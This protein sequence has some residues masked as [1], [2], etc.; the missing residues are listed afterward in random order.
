MIAQQEQHQLNNKN[1]TK[2]PCL[3]TMIFYSGIHLNEGQIRIHEANQTIELKRTK[4]K[5]K[6]I[7]YWTLKTIKATTKIKLSKSMKCKELNKNQANKTK[8]TKT[9]HESL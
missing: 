1:N 9:I 8:I 6:T 7:I 2:T 5:T 3:I 4:V